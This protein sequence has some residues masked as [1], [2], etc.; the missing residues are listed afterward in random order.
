MILNPVE[1]TVRMN[2]H[3]RPQ[4]D[5]KAGVKWGQGIY[6]T[7]WFW[8]MLCVWSFSTLSHMVSSSISPP[9][10]LRCGVRAS[11]VPAGSG[12]W[13]YSFLVSLNLSHTLGRHLLH[14]SQIDDTSFVP[15]TE[16]LVSK[17]QSFPPSAKVECLCPD[18]YLSY[19]VY[20]SSRRGSK[21]CKSAE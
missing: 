16:S 12:V 21:T 11:L 3:E 20:W 2:H 9:L 10:S 8:W 1:W 13:H 14:P 15:E 4:R 17:R 18:R 7:G 19:A 6:S 5:G